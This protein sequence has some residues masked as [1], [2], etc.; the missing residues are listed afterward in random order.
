MV[1]E[2]TACPNRQVARWIRRLSLLSL[3]IASCTVELPKKADGA[4]KTPA[5]GPCA[6]KADGEPCDDGDPT[7][8]TGTCKSEACEPGEPLYTLLVTT[9]AD[10]GKPTCTAQACS[11]RA[12][13]AAANAE[14]ATE[15]VIAF[16]V[17]GT[18]KLTDALPDVVGPISIDAKIPVGGKPHQ[19]TIDGQ[20]KHRLALSNSALTLR[21]L[22]VHQCAASEIGGAIEARKG[23]LVI[24]DCKFDHNSAASRGG[25]IFAEVPLTIVDSDFAHNSTTNSGCSTAARSSATSPHTTAAQLSTTAS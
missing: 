17:D 25:A 2:R 20:G 6:G 10:P 18:V 19:V 5:T 14:I 9:M 13:I 23:K 21:G 4:Y 8:G 24:D 11:L 12:A 16:K 22:R 15:D 3:I 1:G 7:T